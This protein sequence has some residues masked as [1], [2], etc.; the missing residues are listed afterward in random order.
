MNSLW[1]RIVFI[2]FLSG[3]VFAKDEVY[4]TKLEN[5]LQVVVVRNPKGPVVYHSLWYKVGSADSP[6][7]ASGLAHFLEHLMFKGTPKFPDLSFSKIIN[8]MGGI[9]NAHTSQDS[10][11]YWQIIDKQ[12]LPTVME[13]EAD[14]MFNIIFDEKIIEKEKEVV[15]NERRMTIDGSSTGKISEALY[16]TMFWNDPYGKPV[17]GYE[18]EI[19]EYTL[20]K[21][22]E[23]YE[24]WYMPSNAILV[25]AGD[26]TL[27]QVKDLAQ[28]YYGALPKKDVP[29][30][31]RLQE[32]PHHDVTSKIVLRDEHTR[33]VFVEWNYFVPSFFSCKNDLE[34]I[35][36]LMALNLLRIIL[37]DPTYGCLNELLIHQQKLAYCTGT[38]YQGLGLSSGRFSIYFSPELTL[39]VEKIEGIIQGMLYDLALNGPK[40]EQLIKAKE[41]YKLSVEY[42]KRNLTGLADNVANVMLLGFSYHDYCLSNEILEGL[43]TQD[44]KN[45]VEHYLVKNPAVQ[46]Y[47]YPD[48]TK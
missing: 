3:V 17:I 29:V 2:I 16:A 7:G 40:E 33:G 45:A 1:I 26:V 6:A 23:F 22:K 15:L 44:I 34:K 39:D 38:D 37:T 46:L 9:S 8:R 20:Q 11:V 24:K 41:R 21:A 12:H 48:R 31:N 19:K 47:S 14:R 27:D 5:G 30:R 36:S 13:M 18:S 32:P 25:V 35:K 42:Q 10:T 28:K 43:N 4:E